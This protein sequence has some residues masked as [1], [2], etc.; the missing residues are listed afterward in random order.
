MRPCAL[1]AA[2][3]GSQRSALARAANAQVLEVVEERHAPAGADRKPLRVV[4]ALVGDASGCALL[5]A[6]NA[7]ADLLVPGT[8]LHLRDAKAR[9][10]PSPLASSASCRRSRRDGAAAPCLDAGAPPPRGR[11]AG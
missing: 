4:D 1:C 2:R 3:V 10:K 11:P 7:Q 9:A 8:F 6:R 5:S